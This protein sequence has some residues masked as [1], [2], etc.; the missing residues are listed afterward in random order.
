MK[1]IRCILLINLLLIA[2]AFGQVTTHFDEIFVQV[3]DNT[4]ET[5]FAESVLLYQ[6]VG[7]EYD[8]TVQV[9][10]E[11]GTEH[12]FYPQLTQGNSVILHLILTAKEKNDP[13]VIST[14]DVYFYLGDSLSDQITIMGADSNL[15]IYPHGEFIKQKL[16]SRNH[17]A[18]FNIQ[19]NEYGI[20]IAGDFRSEFEYLIPRLSEVEYSNVKMEGT[21]SIP[22]ENLRIGQETTIADAK[23]KKSDIG[24]NLAIAAVAGLFIVIFAIQ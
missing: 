4:V 2:A 21:L 5:Y 23:R 17:S 1:Q 22:E 16:Y 7:I 9:R 13:D 8:T 20:P 19:K 12:Y 24:K 15:Y 6:H 3:N 10:S 18:I 11:K 14:F